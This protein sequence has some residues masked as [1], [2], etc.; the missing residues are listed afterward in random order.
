MASYSGTVAVPSRDQ[1]CGTPVDCANAIVALAGQVQADIA[2]GV[3]GGSTAFQVAAVATSVAPY[4]GTG[5]NALV[6]SALGALG[7]Q[8]AVGTLG[9]GSV[10]FLPAGL[11]NVN[12]VDTGPWVITSIGSALAK[13]ALA[14]PSWWVTGATA[15]F[16]QP[17]FVAPAGATWGNSTWKP[18]LAGALI[19]ATD[20]QFYPRIQQVTLAAMVAG[21]SPSS[22]ALYLFGANS[23]VDPALVTKGG[24][25]GNLYLSTR[26]PGY[27][28]VS[29]VVVSSTS[30]A[31]TSTPQVQVTNW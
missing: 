29:A 30:N 27:P 25:T 4:L 14:R 17:I 11:A 21:V 31:D 8:D 7:A 24:A 9:L 15:S 13:Y 16:S 2:S 5:T 3:A 28:G 23:Q 26:T 6:G 1:I 20:P 22:G 18:M 19:G 10:V 12:A